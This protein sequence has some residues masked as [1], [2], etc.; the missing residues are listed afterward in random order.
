MLKALF[1]GDILHAFDLF[2]KMIIQFFSIKN[3][4]MK[5][6]FYS[7]VLFVF[8][9][10]DRYFDRDV[11]CIREFFARRFNYESEL[12]PKFSDLR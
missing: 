6:L 7:R 3:V 8:V 5:M 12:Y 1:L 2:M 4:L 9:L 10:F 11:T